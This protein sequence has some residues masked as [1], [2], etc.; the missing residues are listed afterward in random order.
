MVKGGIEGKYILVT[1]R[2]ILEEL[3]DRLKNK[4]SLPERDILLFM[5]I[6]FAHFHIVPKASTFSASS[7]P[8][9]NKI[10]ETAF[11]GKADY[12][13]NRRFPFASSQGIQRDKNPDGGRVPETFAVKPLR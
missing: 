2:E 4:F 13:S 10:L 9:D 8:K 3:A 5:D 6:I 11:D 7:D 1:S 12:Y